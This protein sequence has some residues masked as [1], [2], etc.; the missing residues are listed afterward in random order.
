MLW[1]HQAPVKIILKIGIKINTLTKYDYPIKKE[2][3]CQTRSYLQENVNDMEKCM[4]EWMY[5]LE[6]F[7]A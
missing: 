5:I 1:Y 6:Q 3:W 7:T 2:W 4:Y